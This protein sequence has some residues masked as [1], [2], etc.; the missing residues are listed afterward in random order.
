M[1]GLGTSLPTKPQGVD[2]NNVSAMTV[3]AASV[4]I[5]GKAIKE[6]TGSKTPTILGADGKPLKTPNPPKTPVPKIPTG[7]SVW[8]NLTDGA[9]WSEVLRSELQL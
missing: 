7:K 4:V 5:N 2:K 3:N 9:K 8:G 1:R 6:T